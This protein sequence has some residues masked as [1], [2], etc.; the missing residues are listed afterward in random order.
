MKNM[1]DINWHNPQ[2]LY[3]VV[4]RPALPKDTPDVLELTRPIWEGHDYIPYVWDEWLADNHGMLAVAEYGGRVVGLG[5]L[6]QLA[7]EQW[8]LEGLR[9]ALEHQG[10]RIASHLMDYLYGYWMHCAG[11]A[12]RLATAS[13][14]ESVQHLCN[15]FGFRKI[16]EFS[17]FSA[18]VISNDG[19]LEDF[20]FTP[21][22]AAQAIPAVQYAQESQSLQLC[23]GLIDLGYKWAIPVPSHIEEAVNRGDAWWW[24]QDKGLLITM[25]WQEENQQITPKICLLAC[26]MTDLTAILE[27][28]RRLSGTRG[29]DRIGWNAPLLPDLKPI[30]ETC[31]FQREWEDALFIYE[32]T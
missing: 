25:D 30:L 9:V 27:D 28:A 4:C 29:F 8:W 10:R 1:T 15:R 31:G 3:T 6:T 2:D 17:E 32:K 24:H 14:R 7:E 5:K 19:R 11:G 20:G 26:Q 18:P 16:G 22:Q 23:S 12:V 21:V 13:Y